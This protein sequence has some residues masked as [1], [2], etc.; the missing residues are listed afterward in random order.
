MLNV[1]NVIDCRR[2][3]IAAA[4]RRRRATI[5]RNQVG[6]AAKCSQAT[7]AAGERVKHARERIGERLK[8]KERVDVR[9]RGRF[10]RSRH[11]KGVDFVNGFA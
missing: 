3:R 7:L 6:A 11:S 9:H 4:V 8:H 10:E 5:V 1:A 2:R